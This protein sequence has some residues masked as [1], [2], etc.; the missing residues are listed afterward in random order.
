MG[1]RLHLSGDRCDATRWPNL[2]FHHLPRCVTVSFYARSGACLL[3]VVGLSSMIVCFFPFL[4]S[5]LTD[6]IIFILFV[7]CFLISVL[8]LLIFYFILIP[9]IDFFLFCNLVIQLHFLICFIF[10]FSPHSFNF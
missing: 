9:F 2:T 5:L 4:F 8:I 6:K 10:N 1:W 7:F 3:I